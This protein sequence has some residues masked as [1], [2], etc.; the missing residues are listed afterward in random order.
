MPG[1]AGWRE[2][3]L[4]ER[5]T[6]RKLPPGQSFPAGF[7][8]IR[9]GVGEDALERFSIY[10]S[11]GPAYRTDIHLIDVTWRAGDPFAPHHTPCSISFHG[12]PSPH[13]RQ[14]E[15]ALVRVGL[16]YVGHWI[17]EQDR[18]SVGPP[19]RQLRVIYQDHRWGDRGG[20]VI[21]RK[22]DHD[23]Y[24]WIQL[25]RAADIRLD[26]REEYEK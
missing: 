17:R 3:K 12:V 15:D 10:F 19:V 20:L 2:R 23:R 13:R 24:E 7:E 4:V 26:G 8:Q 22:R 1:L 9:D 11:K 21:Q 25:V 18:V 14:L 16:G 6:K 5:I